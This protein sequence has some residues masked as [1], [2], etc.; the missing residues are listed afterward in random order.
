MSTTDSFPRDFLLV[1]AVGGV[2]S[3]VAWLFVRRLVQRSRCWRAVLCIL[4]GATIAPTFFPVLGELVVAPAAF[5]LL[6]V[7][8]GGK[9]ALLG[10]LYG[11]P[12]IL[13]AAAVA[14]AV[15]SAVVSG[16]HGHE[17]PVV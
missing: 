7:S 4:I 14:F 2:V 13:V 1:F 9:N 8:D 11:A 5:M 12:P 3:G 10:I 16:K 15:W 6:L 17:I